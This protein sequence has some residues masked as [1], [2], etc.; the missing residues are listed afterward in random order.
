[1]NEIGG[2]IAF[3][4]ACIAVALIEINGGSAVVIG[5]GLTIWAITTDWCKP[6]K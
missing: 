6:K 1:M 5:M 2:G 4:G 3:A